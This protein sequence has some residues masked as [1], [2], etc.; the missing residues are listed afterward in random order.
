MKLTD[1]QL[2]IL[3]AASQREDSAIELAP[4][5]KGAAANKLV[6]K[7]LADGLIEEIEARGS[8][9]VW[10]RDEDKGPLALRITKRGL[11]AIQINQGSARA[12]A[13]GPRDTEQG[14][15]LP[16][17]KP[18]RRV[19]AALR[20]K[21]RDETLRRSARS[22]HGAS[23]QD[24]M[25]EMLQRR[26]GATIATIMKATGWQSHSVRGF[27]AG[28]VRK[29]LKLTLVSKK[30]GKERVYR[31]VAKDASPKRKGKSGRKAA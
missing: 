4:N 2:V 18:S 22:S 29:K 23:K 30:N 13:E 27:F 12:E 5:L 11:A 31:I 21:S 26:Q 1:T 17:H 7:L 10:R 24:G 9:P 14:T 25:I 19:A 28:V 15:D 8:L 16:R 6:D 20:K 3:S